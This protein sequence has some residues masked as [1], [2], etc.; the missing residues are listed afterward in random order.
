MRKILDTT[1]IRSL[2][3]AIPRRQPNLLNRVA[4]KI[5]DA[6][7]GLVVEEPA[8]G[9]VRGVWQRHGLETFKKRRAALEKKVA[10][11]GLS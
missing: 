1:G 9:Q 4:P 3:R 2:G 8:S 7:E 11:E 5:E 10:E 6:V